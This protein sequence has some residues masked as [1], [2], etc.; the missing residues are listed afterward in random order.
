VTDNQPAG[1]PIRLVIADDHAIFRSGL[2][3]LL[4]DEPGFVVV[5]EA[6]DGEEAVQSVQTLAPDVL[7]LDLSMPGVSGL[8]VVRQL[9]HR[10][11]HSQ[12]MMLTASIASSDIA[13][14]L[15]LGAR[16]VVL[17][18]SAADVLIEGIK[19]VLAGEYW[20][21]Q[22]GEPDLTGALRRAAPP[23]TNNENQPFDLT[24]REREIVSA[25]GIGLGNREI[26]Q[27]FSISE[28]TVKRHLT[29]IFDKTGVSSRLE[30]S[31]FARRHGLVSKD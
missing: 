29:N 10:P 25:V 30:L 12:I 8:D 24:A 6:S 31:V 1:E 21:G 16:G 9:S 19:K 13:T 26:G 3:R 20:V 2:R 17:K 28:K 18:E 4:E 23:T 5:G 22:T 15:Q 14:A 27:L 7:L 11:H